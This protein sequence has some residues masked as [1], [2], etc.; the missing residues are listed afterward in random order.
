MNWWLAGGI[1][2]AAAGLE[3]LA[4]G[5]QVRVVL[6]ALKAPRFAPPLWLWYVI[7]FLYYVTCFVVLGRVLATAAIMRGALVLTLLLMFL[8]TL[9]TY[10]FFRK[11]HL[12]LS[13]AIAACYLPTTVL[14]AYYLWISDRTAAWAFVPYMIYLFYGSWWSYRVWQENV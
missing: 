9:W 5:N 13:A 1:C 4:A 7:G 2:V 11:Q 12:A 14:L 10:V 3:G 8:N 6:G